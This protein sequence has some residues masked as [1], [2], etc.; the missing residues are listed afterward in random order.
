MESGPLIAG[1]NLEVKIKRITIKMNGKAATKPSLALTDVV[2]VDSTLYSG[3]LVG[4]YLAPKIITPMM[5]TEETITD[6]SGPAAALINN[7]GTAK[8]KPDN[9]V[10]VK[11]PFN[12]LKPPPM[13]PTTKNGAITLRINNCEE[14]KVPR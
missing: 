5:I 13:I 14:M 10:M 4:K 11:T 2:A 3:S 9:K 7:S 1:T 6:N 8:A 12:A